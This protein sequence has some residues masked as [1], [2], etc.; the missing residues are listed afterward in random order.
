M[1]N[2]SAKVHTGCDRVFHRTPV[3]SLLNQIGNTAIDGGSH[4]MRLFV[5]TTLRIG[6]ILILLYL[7]RRN[8]GTVPY[9]YNFGGSKK[10]M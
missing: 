1:V 7:F 3:L 6:L 10:H 2:L 8:A 4:N 5:E 9:K